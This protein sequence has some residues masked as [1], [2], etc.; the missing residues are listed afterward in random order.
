MYNPPPPH[1]HIHREKNICILY[2]NIL[3]LTDSSVPAGAGSACC[4]ITG[5]TKSRY[6]RPDVP[7]VQSTILKDVSTNCNSRCQAMSAFLRTLHLFSHCSLKCYSRNYANWKME[8]EIASYEYMEKNLDWFIHHLLCTNTVIG[9]NKTLQTQRDVALWYKLAMPASSGGWG[10][11]KER[12]RPARTVE[13]VQGHRVQFGK[14]L[15]K[16]E[17]QARDWR[18]SSIAECLL[19]RSKAL[20][21]NLRT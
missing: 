12:P 14:T 1:T 11:G 21:S 10:R 3:P 5:C 7:R 16:N 17:Q 15:S 2:K 20:C 4:R 9:R 6:R 19:I 18:C 8:L 13:W